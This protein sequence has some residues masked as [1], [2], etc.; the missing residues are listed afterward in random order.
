M[1][2]LLL[3]ALSDV[4]GP[5]PVA[6]A[7]ARVDSLSGYRLTLRSQGSGGE[8]I[9]HYSYRSPGDVRMDMETPYR[10]A[11]LIYR[12]DTGRVQ[13]WPFGSP[14]R[15]PALSLRPTN[16]MVRSS[17]GH[18]VDQSDV[19]TLLRNVQRLQ[20]HGST[21]R[22]EPV[23]HEGRPVQHVVVEAEP[24]RTVHEVARY[25]LWLDDETLFP[26]RVASYDRRG[27]RMESV[28]LEDVQLDP[29]FPTDHFDP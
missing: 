20:H 28:L 6:E 4:P 10:G 27:Q 21:R 8:E 1:L 22:L 12:H 26:L 9:I 11:V 14:G 24:G 16:R 5:D 18:R 2:P 15:R 29:D 3:L 23:T 13:L 25:D 7:L 19:G 17:Q